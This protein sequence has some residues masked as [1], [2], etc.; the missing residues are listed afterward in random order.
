MRAAADADLDAAVVA[1]RTSGWSWAEIGRVVGITRQSARERWMD[2]R[3]GGGVPVGRP[4]LTSCRQGLSRRLGRL[5]VTEVVRCIGRPA[6]RPLAETV[7]TYMFSCI[8]FSVSW[9][10]RL[11]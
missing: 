5:C 1:A 4:D 10:M 9:R 6:W 2:Q 8:R 7:K 11:L 3:G